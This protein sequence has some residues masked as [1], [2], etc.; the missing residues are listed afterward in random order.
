MSTSLTFS[1]PSR[2]QWL[3]LRAGTNPFSAIGGPLPRVGIPIEARIMQEGVEARV[4]RLA[5]DVSLGD[6]LIGRGELGPVGLRGTEEYPI[7][8]IAVCPREALPL[9]ANPPAGRI[10]LVLT[11]RGLLQMKHRFDPTDERARGLMEPGQWD[12][13]TVGDN[14]LLQQLT[15]S[16]ARSDWYDQIVEPLKL[17][18]YLIASLA[19]P[20]PDKVPSWRAALGHL[21]S[22]QKSLT[23]GN[24]P[25]VFGFCRAALDSLPGAKK[26]I[27]KAMPEG[28]KREEID[29]LTKAIGEYIHSGRHVV[30]GSGGEEAGEFPVDQGDAMFV[31]NLT[32]LLVSRIGGLVL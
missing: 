9:L 26:D 5:F 12:L 20:D 25:A 17:G 14:N 13:V 3:V 1:L 28:K 16:A 4:L 18:S 31:V 11:F 22:A 30:P 27:F 8:A 7:S 19:L 2:H 24:P 29:Q 6:V 23:N 21:A 32:T 15:I 10:N